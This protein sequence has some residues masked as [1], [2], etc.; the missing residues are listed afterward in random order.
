MRRRFLHMPL[1]VCRHPSVWRLLFAVLALTLPWSGLHDAAAQ[2]SQIGRSTGPN[3]DSNAPVTFV[4][5]SVAYDRDRGL[6][7]ATGR[8]EAWQG[9]RVLRAD[10]VIFDRNTNLAAATGHVVIMEPDGQVIF[11]DYAELTQGMKNGVLRGMR[12]LL[13]E[14]G[15]L[16]AN[17]VRRTDGVLNEM[18]RV[19]FSTCDLCKDDPSKPPLWQMRAQSAVQDLERKRIEYVDATLEMFGIPVVYTPYFSHSDPSVKRSSGVL[20]PAMGVSSRLGVFGSLPY[21]AVIDEQ[22]DATITPMFTTRAGQQLGLEVRHRFNAGA[23]SLNGTINEHRGRIEGAVMAR[24]RLNINEDW[25]AGFDISRASSSDYI[26]DFSLGRFAGGTSGVLP[27]QVYLEGFGQGAYFRLDA[28]LY[29]SMSDTIVNAR[30]PQVLPRVQYS[31][32]GERDQLGGR[33][34]LDTNAFNVRRTN[35]ADTRRGAASLSWDR[36]ATGLLGDLWKLTLRADT[37]A[38][39]ANDLNLHPSLLARDKVSLVRAH[40]QLAVEARWP[41]MRDA[42][43]WGSQIIEPIAQVIVG[44]RVRSWQ[45]RTL[46]NEDSLDLEFTDSNLFSFNRYPGLDRLEGGV[47]TNVALRGAWYLGGMAFDGIIGQSFRTE[48]DNFLPTGSGLNG[49]VSDVVARA[50]FAP[51]E[52]LD[53]TYRTR[54]DQKSYRPRLAEATAAVGG[55][56]LRFS[57]GY[58]YSDRN[59]YAL[60]TTGTASPPPSYF[61]TRNEIT[62]GVSSSF[63]NF[64]LS[65][66]ARRDLATQQMVAVGASGA[67][68]DECYIFDVRFQRRYT[69]INKDHGATA[70]LF[71]MTFKPFGQ[72]GFRAM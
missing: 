25:R 44:P 56:K 54:M 15:K 40:P 64:R 68:E 35:G 10:R 45:H 69:S 12:A 17:G 1:F 31:F 6:V 65:G 62:A 19:V 13:A 20:I 72:L 43:A 32:F 60:Y 5:D 49:R 37:L 46:P 14:N 47:R 34:S 58:I 42:G 28:K 2:L 33:F 21:Y 26:R 66:F 23:V 18:S 59:P 39:D 51:T 55:P 22:T 30:L 67:Y 29:Q 9:E 11:A 63:G 36:P 16:A 8:V 41:F 53:L 70:V 3:P 38:Y 48:R 24:G 71:Q 4:A 7:T 61:D 27:S 50:T 52:W 57:A